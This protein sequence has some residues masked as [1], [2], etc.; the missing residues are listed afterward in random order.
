MSLYLT[1]T[2]KYYEVISISTYQVN[3]Y[4]L[5]RKNINMKEI[6]EIIDRCYSDYVRNLG[7]NGN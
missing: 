5:Y 1:H 6:T 3:Q 2:I 7:L 4:G